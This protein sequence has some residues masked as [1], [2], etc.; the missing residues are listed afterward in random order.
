[1]LPRSQNG[2]ST[3]LYVDSGT[4]LSVLRDAA[5]PT[6]C[7]T[8]IVPPHC[9]QRP[10]R[11]SRS[12]TFA[13][14]GRMLIQQARNRI[15]RHAVALLVP[16]LTIVPACRGGMGDTSRLTAAPAGPAFQGTA[17]TG[18]S[19]ETGRDV[20]VGLRQR[21][22]LPRLAAQ[23]S[24]AH[25]EFAGRYQM[26]VLA[27]AI[28]SVRDEWPGGGRCRSAS[29]CDQGQC[30]SGRRRRL[31]RQLG[32]YRVLGSMQQVPTK[33]SACSQS[34]CLLRRRRSPW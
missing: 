8:R 12:R 14:H 22:P 4:G 20:R 9:G 18:L 34:A 27:E 16:P 3:S 23:A 17:D 1:M 32:A 19:G 26:P 2:A 31:L 29:R 6:V 21:C 25:A 10:G 5:H 7:S 28:A 11:A 24:A 30:L 13:S 33:Q 15:A